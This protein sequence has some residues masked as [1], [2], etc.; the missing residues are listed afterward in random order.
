[1]L[2]GNPSV[3][4]F[5]VLIFY[6]CNSC[7]LFPSLAWLL[8]CYSIE[9]AM[10]TPCADTRDRAFRLLVSVARLGVIWFEGFFPQQ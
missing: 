8:L 9:C 5:L 10:R 2:G 1:M 4:F 6:R 3:F 7:F